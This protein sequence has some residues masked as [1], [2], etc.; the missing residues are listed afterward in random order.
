LSEIERDLNTL[1]EDINREHRRCEE[2]VSAALEH[3]LRCGELLGEAKGHIPHGSFSAWVRDHFEG[4]ERT[5]QAYMRLHRNR[6]RLNP[7]RVADLSVRG[8]LTEISSAPRPQ[9]KLADL[10]AKA[11]AALAQIEGAEGAEQELADV[12]EELHGTIAPEQYG[13][14][15]GYY[16][17]RM[18]TAKAEALAAIWVD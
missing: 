2:A 14:L 18:Q 10:E 12:L 13:Y 1:S 8:A 3:A 7:Q 11:E 17:G 15:V 9:P 16:Q 6:D 4:S 5:A